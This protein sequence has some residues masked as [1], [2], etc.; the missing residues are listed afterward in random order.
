MP[1]FRFRLQTLQRLRET[2]RDE[3]RGRLAEAFEAERILGE[4]RAAVAAEAAALAESQRRLMAGGAMDVTRL[5]ESQRYQRLLEAQSRTLAE[6]AAR[7]AAE[8]ESRRQAVVEAERQVRVL[9]KLGER[10]RAQHR[11]AEQAA[12]ARRQDE[13]AT[14]R[15][16]GAGR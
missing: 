4:Q 6:Q 13:I 1:R 3:L 15:W 7:L 5:L 14:T 8:V 12:E 16:E 11:A 9:A 10:R 2:T